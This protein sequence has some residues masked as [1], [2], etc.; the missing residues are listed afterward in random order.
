MIAINLWLSDLC[1]CRRGTRLTVWH[2][3]WLTLFR[4]TCARH[5]LVADSLEMG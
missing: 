5:W 1:P 3:G 2:W 4:H